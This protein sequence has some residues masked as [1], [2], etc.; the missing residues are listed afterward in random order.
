MKVWADIFAIL[1][2]KFVE[3]DD[4]ETIHEVETMRILYLLLKPIPIKV[5]NNNRCFS[6]D[7]VAIL[8]FM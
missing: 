2:V 5:S 6:I 4:V 8:Q 3:I 7:D 1:I